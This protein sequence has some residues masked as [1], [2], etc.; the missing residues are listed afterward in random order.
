ML[1]GSLPPFG[2]VSLIDIYRFDYLDSDDDEDDED[3]D[4][5]KMISPLYIYY[6][7]YSTAC[8]VLHIWEMKLL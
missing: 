2:L 3:D 8:T 1:K 5:K 7:D 4:K 6:Y